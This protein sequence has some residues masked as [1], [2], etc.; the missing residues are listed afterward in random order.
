MILVTPK[1]KNK[2]FQS[3]EAAFQNIELDS[4]TGK[5]KSQ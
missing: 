1:L 2:E 3:I 4:M 5:E